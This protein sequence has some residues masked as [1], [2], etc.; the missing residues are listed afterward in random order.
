MRVLFPWQTSSYGV[1]QEYLG[2]FQNVKYCGEGKMSNGYENDYE[3]SRDV[4][5]SGIWPHCEIMTGISL[6]FCDHTLA[7]L[8]TILSWND[9]MKIIAG[10][11]V[12]PVINVNIETSDSKRRTSYMNFS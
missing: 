4:P 6:I 8:R 12:V 5:N 7:N 10:Q 9:H 11:K 1:P 2:I 3:T